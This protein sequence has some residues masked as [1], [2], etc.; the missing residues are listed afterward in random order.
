LKKIYD[1]TI[2]GGGIAGMTAAIYGCRS[3]KDVLIIERSVFGGQIISTSEIENYPGLSSIKG[4]S[5]ALDLYQQIDRMN[6]DKANDDVLSVRTEDN[7]II[8]EGKK[9]S[10]KC[11]TAIIAV[12]TKNR[13]LSLP[14][15][16]KF[17]GKGISYCATCDGAF[18]KNKTV[19][20]VGGGNTA[21]EE[22]LY[23][24]LLCKEVYL[25]HRRDKFSGENT[26][27]KRVFESKNIKIL[28]NTKV[29]GLH[30]KDFLEKIEILTERKSSDPIS[31]SSYEQSYKNVENGHS[32]ETFAEV[33]EIECLF[34]AIG[35]IPQNS[36][37][38][39]ITDLDENGYIIADETCKTRTIGVFAAGD[40]RSKEL[41]QL[42]TAASDGAAAASEAIK[43]LN[44]QT[45]KI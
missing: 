17:I 20:V 41:R 21:L 18:Y 44:T 5:F 28:F 3:G 25:I 36:S 23:L 1:I 37:F 9:D 11:R 35:Q 43:L 30:G 24:S 32:Q 14:G 7:I 8:I 45:T 19:A 39:N 2:I 4:Y 34:T 42:V 31:G 13:A 38:S 12:G 6:A 40:C 33:L 10:Y 22:A 26:L 27:Q 15:E 29:I 16:E